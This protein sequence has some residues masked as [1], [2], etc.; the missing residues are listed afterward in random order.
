[1]ENSIE[2][3]NITDTLVPHDMKEI[4]AELGDGSEEDKIIGDLFYR[5]IKYF[6]DFGFELASKLNLELVAD[7]VEKALKDKNKILIF[8]YIFFIIILKSY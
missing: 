3:N 1:M 5:S 2:E 8:F 4:F 7:S 6:F